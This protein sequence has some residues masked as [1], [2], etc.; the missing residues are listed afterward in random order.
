MAGGIFHGGNQFP[1]AGAAP[2]ELFEQPSHGLG[3][4]IVPLRRHGGSRLVEHRG[5]QSFQAGEVGL[6]GAP[7]AHLGIDALPVVEAAQ[8][9]VG[10]VPFARVEAEPLVDHQGAVAGALV[11]FGDENHLAAVGVAGKRPLIHVIVSI[12]VLCLP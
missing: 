1:D 6:K 9:T 11:G 8:R 4:G 10:E 12:E 5:R 3:V 2:V 7:A